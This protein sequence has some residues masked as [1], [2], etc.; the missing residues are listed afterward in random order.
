MIRA[1]T[2]RL[3]TGS[4]L[5]AAL[6]GGGLAVVSSPAIAAASGTIRVS[7]GSLKVR[8]GPSTSAKVV[9][10][11]RN[12]SHVR[13][14]CFV[15]GQYIRGSVR[16]TT[17][18]DRL[19]NGRYVSHAYVRTTAKLR[20]CAAPTPKAAPVKAAPTASTVITGSV[21]SLDGTVNLR[22]GPS[23][24]STIV[25]RAAHAAKLSISCAV[26]G[27]HVNGTVRAT[28]QWDRLTNGRYISAGYVV[29]PAVP[30][31][32]GAAAPTATVP[33]TNA[34]FIKTAVPGAQRGW[35]DYGVPPSVTIAQAILESGWGRSGLAANDRNYFGIKC[36]NG[37][38]GTI[39]AGCH[40]YKTSECTK[41]GRCFGTSASFRTYRA[42][43]DSFRDHGHFLRV[44][45]RYR[46]A[47]KHTKD[48][49]QF[50]W[51]VW[52]AG[53]ATDPNYYTKVT[54]LMRTYDL[55]RYDTW[56]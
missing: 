38:P 28:N 55:Y 33:T 12:N 36:F 51:Q 14:S 17:A 2:R 31:C 42:A 5:A 39:A 52:K 23:T 22:S 21:K 19:S 40:T 10:A 30:V 56:R 6:A 11:L 26:R 25:G 7:G 54:N 4:L 41:A 47:F 35:R 16:A 32:S 3:L 43:A 27:D 15:R 9:A 49:N 44:N 18:W 13:I 1:A 29:S 45:N 34:Q 46:N 24:A 53:Y 48:A 20:D 8:T 37:R 50:L